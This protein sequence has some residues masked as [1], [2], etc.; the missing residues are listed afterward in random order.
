MGVHH[1]RITGK[2]YIVN[3]IGYVVIRIGYVVI[4][5]G[6]VVF[7]MGYVVFQMGYVVIRSIL[8]GVRRISDRVCTLLND[9]DPTHTGFAELRGRHQRVATIATPSWPGLNGQHEWGRR[10]GVG[11]EKKYHALALSE[12]IE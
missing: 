6:Y 12:G 8:D 3:Q 7:W 11:H 9:L 5:I 10:Q 4:R 2:R 1:R